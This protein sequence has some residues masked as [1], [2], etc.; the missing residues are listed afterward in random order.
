MTD[1]FTKHHYTRE[2]YIS[3]LRKGA[4]ERAR[5]Y[6]FT[7]KVLKD[8]ELDYKELLA[9]II[10]R[11]SD[12]ITENAFEYDENHTPDEYLKLFLTGD[13]AEAD[14]FGQVIV[15]SDEKSAIIR[16]YDCPLAAEWKAMG[17]SNDEMKEV[18]DLANIMDFQTAKRFGGIDL[19]ID[20]K[21]GYNDE[22]CQLTAIQK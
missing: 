1:F 9:E 12:S 8:R 17:I 16:M 20:C 10:T 3:A 7:M 4:A 2:E 14:A 19:H 21:M 22:F 5:V 6:Y 15:K 11:F 18:C 13:T